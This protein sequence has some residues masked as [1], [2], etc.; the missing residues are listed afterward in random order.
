VAA[1]TAPSRYRPSGAVAV[2]I[3]VLAGLL[4]PP[5]PT[6]AHAEAGLESQFVAALN[7]ARASQGLPALAIAGELTSVARAHSRVMADADHLHHNPDLGSAVS[8]WRKIGENVGRGPSVS[9][10]HGALMNSPGHR[11]NIL[12][13]DWTQ[14]GMGV[15]VE[16]GQLWVTQVFRT[17]ANAAP[18]PAPAPAPPP[19]PEPRADPAQEPSSNG[20]SSGPAPDTERPEPESSDDTGS[21]AASAGTERSRR[22]ATDRPAAEPEPEPHPVHSP[23][24]ALDRMT[25]LLVRQTATEGPA[26]F[27]EIVATLE[28]ADG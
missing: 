2:L 13:P 9:S 12:D 10:I 5:A 3:L 28:I 15:V 1:T 14:L 19:D 20:A 24:L 18:A 6:A 26:S 7:S 25:L 22:A 27:A 8:G 21:A 16:D 23:P 17:P 4:V 11:R